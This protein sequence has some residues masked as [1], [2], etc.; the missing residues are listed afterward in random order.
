[1]HHPHQVDI[2]HPLP[3][4]QI[5]LE[6]L[7]EVADT[8]V[9]DQYIE[10]AEGQMHLLGKRLHR[11]FA[12]NVQYLHQA[13]CTEVGH[14]Q[15]DGTQRLRVDVGGDDV[16]ATPGERQRRRPTNAGAGSGDE[17]FF[18]FQFRDGHANTCVIN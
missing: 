10:R 15:L 9:I 1:M 4:G 6:K 3:V 7:A 18:V 17:D 12:R 16:G 13:G 11:T 2:H 14:L 5:A 8:R